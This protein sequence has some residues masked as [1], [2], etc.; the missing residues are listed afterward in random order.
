MTAGGANMHRYK[1]NNSE[2]SIK[3]YEELICLLKQN[4]HELISDYV[5]A[6]TKITID[7]K[8]GHQPHSMTANAYKNGNRCPKCPSITE[9]KAK[10]EFEKL[11]NKNGHILLSEYKKWSEKV[12]I[13]M[14]EHT[15]HWITPNNYVQG[16]RCPLCFTFKKDAEE[17]F[18]K[19][20]EKNGHSLMSDYKSSKQKVLIKMCEHEPCWITPNNY[21]NGARC[22]KCSNNS[23]EQ[24]SEKLIEETIK[25]GHTL[26]TEYTKNKDKVLIDFNCGHKPHWITPNDYRNGRGCPVCRRALSKGE[27]RVASVLDSMNI[28]YVREYSIEDL[29]YESLLRFD[30]YLPKLNMCIEYDGKQHFEPVDYAGKGMENAKEELKTTQIKDGLKN[31]YCKKKGWKMVRIPYWEYNNI[32]TILENELH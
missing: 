28:E 1:G 15:P 22:P 23:S 21:T 3:A 25:N 29:K 4:G 2:K 18:K 27:E 26:L 20:V 7:F 17:R 31:N 11:V 6:R 5:N 30:F 13:K 9:L 10:E 8:C 16:R 19:L 24:S 14:C 12:L 32:K